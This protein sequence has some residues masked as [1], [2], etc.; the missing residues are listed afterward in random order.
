[1]KWLLVISDWLLVRPVV[2]QPG[3]ALVVSEVGCRITESELFGSMHTGMYWLFM[4]PAPISRME[5][6]L[7]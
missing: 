4:M 7:G 2:A 6:D 5:N 1:M 3:L